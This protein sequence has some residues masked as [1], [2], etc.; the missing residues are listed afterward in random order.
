M[1]TF[2]HVA[3]EN[4]AIQQ[5]WKLFDKKNSVFDVWHLVEH[6]PHS[7]LKTWFQVEIKSIDQ[8]LKNLEAWRHNMVSHRSDIGH[9]DPDEFEQKFPDRFKHE[10]R[11]REFLLDLICQMKFEMQRT[12]T[13]KT[14]EKFIQGLDSYKRFVLKEKKKVM[15]NET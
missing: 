15:K 6:M 12:S 8:S 1:L 11:I 7:N 13:Q 10:E 5:L 2:S 4:Y 9:M 14:R 3:L